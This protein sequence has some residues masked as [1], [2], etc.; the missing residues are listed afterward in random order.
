MKHSSARCPLLSFTVTG[1][2]LA[3]NSGA[4]HSGPPWTLPTLPTP[5]LRYWTRPLA[6]NR[7]EC[8]RPNTQPRAPPRRIL[9]SLMEGLALSH[10]PSHNLHWTITV[11]ARHEVV[12]VQYTDYHVTTYWCL[13]RS[14]S[15]ATQR[16]S[17]SPCYKLMPMCSVIRRSNKIKTVNVNGALHPWHPLHDG[18]D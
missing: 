1:N 9:D 2:L 13:N 15:A 3:W 6:N 8:S 12:C 10:S 7:L 16:N 4:L 17:T 18:L 11:R 5:L 14:H